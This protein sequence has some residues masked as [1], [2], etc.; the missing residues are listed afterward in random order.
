MHKCRIIPS[1]TFSPNDNPPIGRLYTKAGLFRKEH[2]APLS[3]SPS[4][5]LWCPPSKG[6]TVCEP[7]QGTKNQQDR[8]G[9]E[10]FESKLLYQ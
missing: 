3:S 7:T 1:A 6:S 9:F 5:M 2:V 8:V 4:E 10:Q